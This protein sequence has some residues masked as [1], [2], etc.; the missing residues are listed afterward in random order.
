MKKKQIVPSVPKKEPP[1]YTKQQLISCQKFR[2]RRDILA[3]ILEDEKTYT[4][5]EAEQKLSA[6]LK[7]RV[8]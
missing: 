2:S 3:V 7:R 8:K 1:C 4:M 5:Q 6:F